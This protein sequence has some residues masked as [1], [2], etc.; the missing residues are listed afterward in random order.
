MK[1][2][3]RIK[4]SLLCILMSLVLASSL[5][6]CSLK[7]NAEEL[8]ASY[9]RKATDS[10]EVTE[11]FK[12]A[13]ADFSFRLLGQ[14][15]ADENVSKKENQLI[16]P[17]SAALCLAMVTN[18]ADGE[19]LAQL[20]QM[21]GMEIE[22]LNKS[23]YAYVSSLYSADDCK[24]SLANSIWI[25]NGLPVKEEFLQTNADWYDAEVFSAPFD[26]STLKDINNWCSNKT[27]G[28]VDKAIKELNP[29]TVMTLI[30]AL[31][32]DAKWEKAYTND[33]IVSLTF[34]CFDGTKKNAKFLCSEEDTFISMDGAKGIAKNYIGGKYSI[35]CLLPDEGTDVYDFISSVDGSK[36]MAAW[37]GRSHKSVQARIPEFE[38]SS[39]IG[40]NEILKRMGAID[41]FNS[42][43]A[44]FS[45]IN[46]DLYCSS[47]QQKTYIKVDRNGTKAAAITWA[48]M[49]EA[50][51]VSHE[52][53]T[54]DRPFAY[55]IVDNATGLPMFIGAVGKV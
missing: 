18:G 5:C 43:K 30:N 26:N 29:D 47:V 52:T 23:L 22:T 39:D 46:D 45:K 27:N 55:A 54:F 12:T 34:E 13:M 41:M 37:N 51:D 38:Y 10:G 53:L 32:F 48:Q 17:L 44:N 24:L 3:K 28:M 6:S 25:K 50:A 11:E 21:F 33:D 20:E 42:R 8:S 16:S 31:M 1:N 15:V 2:I 14:T 4:V 40:L 7:V 36:W 19:T 49:D 35:V 9:T